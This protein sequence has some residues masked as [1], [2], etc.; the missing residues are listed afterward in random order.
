MK[1]NVKK[2]IIKVK[3]LIKAGKQAIVEI[4]EFKPAKDI[5]RFFK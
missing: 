5:S 2:N 3:K 4:E 1:D